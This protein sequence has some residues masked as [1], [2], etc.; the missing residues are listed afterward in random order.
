MRCGEL[1]IGLLVTACAT[2]AS[3]AQ[4][5]SGLGV[6][7][8]QTH[9]FVRDMSRDGRVVV[10]RSTDIS[11][12]WT[13][14]TGMQSLGG[15]A[16]VNVLC[17]SSDGRLAVQSGSGG[18]NLIGPGGWHVDCWNGAAGCEA[19]AAANAGT[20]LA[21]IHG[22]GMGQI[23]TF[24]WTQ[25]G[26]WELLSPGYAAGISDDGAVVVGTDFAWSEN[27]GIV[28]VPGAAAV[29][30]GGDFIVG[31]V[32]LA[33]YLRTS[34]GKM[35]ELGQGAPRSVSADGRVVVGGTGGQQ[36]GAV[37]WIDGVRYLLDEYLRGRGYTVV[38][39]LRNAMR[40][41]SDGTTVVGDGRNPCAGSRNEA[42]RARLDLCAAD[43]NEDHVVN[44]QDFFDFLTDFFNG[45]GNFNGDCAGVNSQDF[46]DF[47]QAFFGG[48]H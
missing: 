28:S 10:G 43:W 23:G 37:V 44:S 35:T 19:W 22:L 7:P 45:S 32:Q 39:E 25:T 41:S 48:C 27:N 12:R 6:L 46:F 15:G 36:P 2:N 33:A 5:F 20:A 21:V 9:S 26:G 16:G 1:C 13:R 24:R 47:L 38:W 42:W 14:E 8:N 31:S 29:S 18:I 30:G 3:R 40:V 34:D 4:A 11:F 17:I